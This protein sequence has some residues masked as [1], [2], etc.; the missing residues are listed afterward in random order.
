MNDT[1]KNSRTYNSALNL[2]FSLGGK[3]VDL[4]LKFLLRT[5]FIYTLGKEYLGLSGLFTN[6]LSLLSLAELGIGTAINFSLY[7]PI[8]KN[9][10][11]TISALMKLYRKAYVIIGIAVLTIGASLTPFLGFFIDE[12][13]DIP[14]IKIIYLLFVL[15]SGISYFYSYKAS[16]ISANQKNYIVTNNTYLFTFLCSF[17]QVIVL[18]VYHDYIAYLVIQVLF[19]FL[20]NYRISKKAEKLY[21][22]LKKKT[23]SKIDDETK[24]TLIKNVS[25]LVFHRIGAIVVFS[26]DNILLSKIFG[27]IIVGIYSN[28]T[29]IV[30]AVEGILNQVCLAASASIGNLKVETEDN[31]Q[32]NVFNRLYFVNF[33]LFSV[34]A[35]M[36]ATLFQPF[37][38]LWLGDSFLMTYICVIFV[39]L[40]F[41]LKGM[42][43]TVM[44]FNTSYGL[45]Q[46]YKYM[47]IPECLINLGSSI[48][49][50][51]LIG[52]VGIFIGT[53]LSTLL[54][55][56]WIEP[57]VLFKYGIKEMTMILFF[58]RY[59]IYTATT[60][61][62]F[63]LVCSA[64]HFIS[65]DG[66]LG[67]I[68]NLFIAF[69]LPNI[70]IVLVF[71]KT[72][73]FQYV[74][75]LGKRLISK[76]NLCH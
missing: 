14:H 10:N 11:D 33:W 2:T 5:V 50:A 20:A 64:N 32:K 69:V 73:E 68:I 16:Y 59:S 4:L 31:H 76:M 63:L 23:D 60:M 48:I 17:I 72:E 54:T 55:S 62:S 36:L 18:L 53:T 67:F 19:T 43:Q 57:R 61:V 38:K 51:Y 47:P 21:P 42:R 66:I 39:S 52:P 28:Y 6:I 71:G 25:A 7:K 27:I 49:L 45:V 70:L 30:N 74:V 26:T 29:M 8:A 22:V 15:N 3:I 58:K 46:Y 34:C 24:E 65:I 44:T 56:F 35:I 1:E 40:N 75:K 9:D 41:Y 13:P 12:M 37:I